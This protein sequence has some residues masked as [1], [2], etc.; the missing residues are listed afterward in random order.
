MHR[1]KKKVPKVQNPA[2][3]RTQWLF[4]SNFHYQPSMSPLN[5]PTIF[6][7]LWAYGLQ[8]P[9]KTKTI[10]VTLPSGICLSTVDVHSL[11]TKHT[12]WVLRSFRY[13]NLRAQNQAIKPSTA[14]ERE[15][16]KNFLS[17]CLSSWKEDGATVTQSDQYWN[18]F[19]GNT[20]KTYANTFCAD[21]AP[22]WT[23][24]SCEHFL[25]CCRTP[26]KNSCEQFLHW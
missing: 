14:K 22:L 6:S 11:A 20:G 9:K 3:C 24:S 10:S 17:S 23:N 7:S 16:H 18:Y 13:Y 25:H 1:R 4:F 12:Q 2:K 21:K 26:V 8:A 5:L 19:K 15:V